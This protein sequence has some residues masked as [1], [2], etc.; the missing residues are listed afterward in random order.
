MNTKWSITFQFSLPV[1]FVLFLTLLRF[2]DKELALLLINTKELLRN[3]ELWKF[4]GLLRANN[5][6][7]SIEWCM[8]NQKFTD[9]HW[10]IQGVCATRPWPQ[11]PGLWR[12]CWTLRQVKKFKDD[13]MLFGILLASIWKYLWRRGSFFS[14]LLDW[15]TDPRSNPS[16][17]STPDW[18]SSHQRTKDWTLNW[19]HYQ[20]LDPLPKKERPWYLSCGTSPSHRCSSRS[21]IIHFM[22]FPLLLLLLL[23]LP[24]GH[25]QSKRRRNIRNQQQKNIW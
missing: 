12:S 2:S 18:P 7:S 23:L 16:A 6:S 20:I 19:N 9:L 15:T 25:C 3:E 10:G 22:L 21:E 4:S 13:F 14:T 24:F 1:T 8:R 17:C 5:N 11:E